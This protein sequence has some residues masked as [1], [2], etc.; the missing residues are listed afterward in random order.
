MRD[1]WGAFSN[2]LQVVLCVAYKNTQ[3]RNDICLN[4][5]YLLTIVLTL[6]REAGV[7]LTP[8]PIN[9]LILKNGFNLCEPNFVTFNIFLLVLIC[10]T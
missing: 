1:L 3:Y 6:R 10:D 5:T 7:K 4:A 8:D 9:L 2:H